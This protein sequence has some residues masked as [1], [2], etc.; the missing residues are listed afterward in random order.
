MRGSFHY[1]HIADEKSPASGGSV[2]HQIHME[3][4]IQKQAPR[5]WEKPITEKF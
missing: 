2:T 5:Q 1:H 4:K 3:S